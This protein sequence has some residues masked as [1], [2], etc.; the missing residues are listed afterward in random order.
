[1]WLAW[2]AARTIISERFGAKAEKAEAVP[3]P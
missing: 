3:H 1:L 2:R